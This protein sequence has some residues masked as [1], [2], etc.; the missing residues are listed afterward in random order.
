MSSENPSQ[1]LR[2]GYIVS[3][4]SDMVWFLALPILALLV[5]LAC[6]RWLSAAAVTSVALLITGPHH[7]V[8]L[9]RTAALPED[10]QR[11]ASQMFVGLIVIAALVAAGYA[12]AP[13]TLAALTVIWN[14]Q[15]SMMQIHGFSRIYDFK[16]ETA[17]KNS[18]EWDFRLNVVLSANLFVIAPAF[19]NFWIRE[20]HRFGLPVSADAARLIQNTSWAITG[21]TVLAYAVWNLRLIRSGQAV[22]PI[23][24][25]FLLSSYGILYLAGVWMRS[26]LVFIITAQIVHGVQYMVIVYYFV[27]RKS[28]SNQTSWLARFVVAPHRVAAFVL[29]CLCYVAVIQLIGQ[30]PFDEL[31]FGLTSSLS[32]QYPAIP[33]LGMGAL[34]PEVGQ[35]SIAT[36]IVSLP[37]MLHLYYDSFIWKVRE[38]QSQGGL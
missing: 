34:T 36:V 32:N 28:E 20:L 25:L 16:A 29:M 11:F 5:G 30:R 19:S 24:M 14:Q 9:F 21:L 10:R 2:P 22:N 1:M 15:H 8:T 35:A 17:H 33:A 13:L 6:Q 18:R 31:T 23:K 27:R 3:R 12:Y 38:Q 26:L 7:F 37:G 4:S